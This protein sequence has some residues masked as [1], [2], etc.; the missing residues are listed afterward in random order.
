MADQNINLPIYVIRFI[1][2]L[3]AS[4]SYNYEKQKDFHIG[5]LVDPFSN[6]PL[7][8]IRLR[9]LYVA[10]DEHIRYLYA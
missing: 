1:I 3:Y 5:I 7:L 10:F 6:T 2:T 8:V 9:I 4:P